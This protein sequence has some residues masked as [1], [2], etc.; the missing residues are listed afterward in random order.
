MADIP[1][2]LDVEHRE[3]L[4][5]D[6]LHSLPR[7]C[8]VRV[9]RQIAQ[10]LQRDF[11]GLLPTELALHVL[12]FL[13]YP[14]LLA[15]CAV[16]RRWRVLGLDSSLWRSLCTAR[17]WEWKATN[18]RWSVLF[19]QQL[20]RQI[21]EDEGVGED[22]DEVFTTSAL[23]DALREEGFVDDDELDAPPLASSSTS[24]AHQQ[25][26]PDYKLLYQTRT[27]LRSRVVQGSYRRLT[28]QTRGSPDGHTATIY[29][30]QLHSFPDGRQVLFTGSRDTTIRQW[31]LSRGRV[32]RVLADVHTGSV[33]SLCAHGKYLASAGSDMVVVIWDVQTGQ[34]LKLLTDHTDGVLCVRFD[35]KRLV[36]CS[37]GES[38]RTHATVRTYLFPDLKPHLVLKTHRAAVNAVAISG[39]Q[40]ASASGDR[41]VCIWDAETG[42]LL[43]TLESHHSR[44]IASI[45]FA[46]PLVL[47]GS[48][49]KH[50]RLFNIANPLG[51]WSTSSELVPRTA[52][53]A[54]LCPT[55]EKCGADASSP[56]SARSRWSRRKERE[57]HSELVR[58]VALGD[59][60]CISGS[61]DGTVKI[62]DRKSGAL[63]ADLTGGHPGR[64]FCVGFDCTKVVSCGEE[65]I[66]IW[67]F[68][69]GIETSFVK[70]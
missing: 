11:I 69:H 9:H 5:I 6:L 29:C 54:P 55:C 3:R 56:K 27:L 43:H 23:R 7:D 10:S 59:D 33:L 14:S 65:Q 48:S 30:L 67:D 41:S 50:L 51:G 44:G 46:P 34:V 22:E 70:L 32:E 42:A 15:C 4:V 24:T 28:L 68:G 21:D 38:T 66:S 25:S 17:G 40:I 20:Q 62:W 8:L 52:P 57:M 26:K 19:Y 31:D 12:S 63:I 49:D 64:V 37:K 60:M 16:S 36:S 47:T 45:D 35:D 39:N 61:Y 53:V 1:L 13:P 18:P 58:S 2:E